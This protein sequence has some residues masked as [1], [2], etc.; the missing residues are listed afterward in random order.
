MGIEK[1]F[2]LGLDESNHIVIDG[3][4]ASVSR[5]HAS[6]TI[7]G[8]TWVLKD[9]QSTNGTFVEENGEFRRYEK[10]KIT[11]RTWIRLGETG[12]RGYYFKARRV[13][14]PNDYRED[15]EELFAVF[16]EYEDA[17]NQLESNRRA[18]KFITPILMCIGLASS[19]LPVIKDNGMAVRASFMLPGFLS[20]FIQDILLHRLEKKVKKLQDCLIC[21]KCRRPL[22]KNDILNREHT[23]CHAH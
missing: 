16:Q 19:F 6:I 13:L 18:V 4:H 12:H 5:N 10:I 2:N 8:D 11:P 7:D 17:K 21:P 1:T 14:K 22:G 23:I 3:K 20:P 9:R 15:F